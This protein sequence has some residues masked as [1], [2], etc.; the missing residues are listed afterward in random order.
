ML[1]AYALQ[2]SIKETVAE[3]KLLYKKQPFHL[4]QRI[5]MLLLIKQGKA[6]SKRSLADAMG[7]NHNSIQSWRTKYANGRING[8]LDFKRTSHRRAVISGKIK[9]AV[10]L[11]LHS[12]TDAFTSY[13]GLQ[14]WLNKKFSLDMQYQALYIYLKRN[15]QTKLKVVRKSQVNKDEEAVIAFKKNDSPI[16]RTGQKQPA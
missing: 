3:L 8:L 6:T 14:Q 2:L 9:K 5:Q 4:K 12:P 7:V 11:R 13:I 15:Y 16:R 1:L 10:E